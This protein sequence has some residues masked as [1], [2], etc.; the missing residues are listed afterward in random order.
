MV[1]EPQ[2]RRLTLFEGV[3][4]DFLRNQGIKE[5]DNLL[6]KL[7]ES[8]L[9]RI[10]L[11]D[12]GGNDY[13][14][15][16]DRL[17]STVLKSKAKFI[18]EQSRKKDQEIRQKLEEERTQKVRWKLL[19]YLA[20]FIGVFFAAVAVYAVFQTIK[21][22]QLRSEAENLSNELTNRN[23][24]LIDS[25]SIRAGNLLS[26]IDNNLN[27]LN[28]ESAKENLFEVI[29]VVIVDSSLVNSFNGDLLN[30][31]AELGYFYYLLGHPDTATA[32]FSRI[33]NSPNLSERITTWDKGLSLLDSINQLA[34]NN[35]SSIQDKYL[36]KLA[37]VNGGEF[38]MGCD[39]FFRAKITEDSY[40]D[41]GIRCD[42]TGE[43]EPHEVLVSDFQIGITEVTIRQFDLFRRISG[44]ELPEKN[45][46][47]VGKFSGERPVVGINWIEAAQYTNWLND[48]EN[49]P[50]IYKIDNKNVSVENHWGESYRLPTEAEWEFAARGG[51]NANIEDPSLF[52]GGDTLD[53]VGWYYMNTSLV[54]GL[55]E[56]YSPTQVVGQKR[57]NSLG[58]YDMSGNVWEWCHD[59]YDFYYYPESPKVNPRGPVRDTGSRVLRGGSVNSGSTAGSPKLCAV[60]VRLDNRS[61]FKFRG[62]FH[63][64]RIAKNINN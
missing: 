62:E 19:T 36:P 50:Q 17:I 16:H 12:R 37:F 30:K 55:R 45:R 23:N 10:E 22:S 25:Y 33:I 27:N 54:K 57:P 47:Q 38:I 44:I 41:Y 63:G 58:I 13:E 11:G 43:K 26:E 9:I 51:N 1:Y 34:P 8:R 56:P 53:L 21:A 4:L 6:R 3:I 7:I 48:L 14:L 40:I 32:I 60:T 49:L 42:S 46:V 5:P 2:Q 61:F 59:I 64:F 35:F 39:D 20:A 18:E 52:S 29:K 31:A 15:S 28:Y 24:T